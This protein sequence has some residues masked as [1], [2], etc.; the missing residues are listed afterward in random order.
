MDPVIAFN[1]PWTHV[2][3]PLQ[4]RG[5][6]EE[7]EAKVTEIVDSKRGCLITGWA[8]TGKTHFVKALCNRLGG[9]TTKLAP[10][11]MACLLLGG[12]TFHSTF[13]INCETQNYSVGLLKTYGNVSNVVV[14]EVSMVTFLEW[15]LL[16]LIKRT[17]N[18]R[19]FLVGDF[20]QCEPVNEGSKKEHNYRE[21]YLIK[22]LADSQYMELNINQRSD[23]RMWNLVRRLLQ[24]GDDLTGA[25]GIQIYSPDSSTQPVIWKHL[26][27][28][29]EVRIKINHMCVEKWIKAKPLYKSIFME[30]MGP[31]K[32]KQDYRI[33]VGMPIISVVNNPKLKIVN[34]E[35]FTV[36]SIS[37]RII[38][39]KRINDVPPEVGPKV[40]V[41]LTKFAPQFDVAFCITVH[42]SQGST[43]KEPYVIWQW[44]TMG[45]PFANARRRRRLRYT[46][47]TRTSETNHVFIA[48]GE[49]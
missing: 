38:T 9:A 10:T 8:G 36:L 7:V 6:A 31:P 24:D 49:P 14:D 18:P 19:I 34:N 33:T 23:D 41:L 39:L 37:D 11:N 4:Q 21:H 12:R 26:A 43:Y 15:H 30:G 1:P 47:L 25:D 32:H 5:N 2:I 35:Q 13:G 46:A 40:E 16:D 29:N 17:W 28:S 45:G 48:L 44:K 22:S 42:R 3:S 27:H 20:E